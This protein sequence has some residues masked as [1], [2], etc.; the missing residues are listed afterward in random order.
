MLV[1]LPGDRLR[2][3][4]PADGGGCAH[5]RLVVEETTTSARASSV[6]PAGRDVEEGRDRLR[7][8]LAGN[9]ARDMARARGRVSRSYA[10]NLLARL[11]TEER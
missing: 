10:Y 5:E 7:E 11:E 9:G 2:R 3:R 4:P 1:L 6:H 8:L